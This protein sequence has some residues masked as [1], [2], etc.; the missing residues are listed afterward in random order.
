MLL[1]Y[2]PNME[3]SLWLDLETTGQK[4]CILYLHDLKKNY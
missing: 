3:I 4:N 1:A 2:F